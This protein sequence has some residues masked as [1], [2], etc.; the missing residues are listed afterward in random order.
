MAA[1]IEPF[2]LELG[3]RIH[4]RRKQ[5]GLTQEKLGQLLDPQVTRA[6]IANI[7]MGAQRVLVHTLAQLAV[8]LGTS[9]PELLPPVKLRVNGQDEGAVISKELNKQ[10]NLSPKQ[11]EQLMKKLKRRTNTL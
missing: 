6:S 8:H 11:V 9:V 2:Y 7:E 5:Q 10:L 1:N 3:R 4:D